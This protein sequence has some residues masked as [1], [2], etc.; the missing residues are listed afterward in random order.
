MG[1]N[2]EETVLIDSH[3]M[4]LTLSATNQDS[5]ENAVF[6]GSCV[7]TW[8]PDFKWRLGCGHSLPSMYQNTRLL[9]RKVGSYV[10][11]VF[12]YFVVVL[13]ATGDGN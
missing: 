2:L 10:V 4:H 1:W 3:R 5:M 8:V 13:L 12:C 11:G 9:E 6:R 7:E